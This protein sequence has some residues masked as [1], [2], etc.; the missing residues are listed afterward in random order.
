LFLEHTCHHT[1]RIRPGQSENGTRDR[2]C[3]KETETRRIRF[4]PH[5]RVIKIDLDKLETGRMIK[6]DRKR[7]RLIGIFFFHTPQKSKSTL[8]NWRRRR[9]A[10]SIAWSA[11]R[12]AKR[13]SAP[14]EETRLQKN[15]AYR[16]NAPYSH[17]SHESCGNLETHVVTRARS[18]SS[19]HVTLSSQ[20]NV[21]FSREPCHS[22]VATRATPL[23]LSRLATHLYFRILFCQTALSL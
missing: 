6:S 16:R 19:S 20:K 4:F 7:Q 12:T 2:E 15:R 3:P 17:M 11:R 13:R 8:I 18:R 21:T 1:N 14:K 10:I 23:S 9:C 5:T 22:H